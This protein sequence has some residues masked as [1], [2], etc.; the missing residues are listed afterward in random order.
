MHSALKN[1]KK[2]FADFAPDIELTC[3]V[4]IVIVLACVFSVIPY[5]FDISE[6]FFSLESSAVISGHG[7]LF[8]T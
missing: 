2:T 1:L 3:G 5:Y 8:K 4:V 7:E 6:H